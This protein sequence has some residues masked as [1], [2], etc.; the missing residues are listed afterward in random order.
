MTSSVHPV[1]SVR[2]ER[3][4]RCA[5][6]PRRPVGRVSWSCAAAR[7]PVRFRTRLSP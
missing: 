4:S 1:S 7:Q 5:A 2:P 3:V 6:R